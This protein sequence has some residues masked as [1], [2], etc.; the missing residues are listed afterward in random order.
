MALDPALIYSIFEHKVDM[1]K[2][3]IKR[4]TFVAAIPTATTLTA[5]DIVHVHRRRWLRDWHTDGQGRSHKSQP[6]T[7]GGTAMRVWVWLPWRWSAVVQT[8]P[9]VATGRILRPTQ[10]ANLHLTCTAV[11]QG[12]V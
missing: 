12:L 5:A 3:I 6:R 11:G 8:A 4:N 7:P 1:A 2:E 10:P 9:L